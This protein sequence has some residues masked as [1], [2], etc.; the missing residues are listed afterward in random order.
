[1]VWRGADALT[2]PEIWVEDLVL[3]AR[4][5]KAARERLAERAQRPLRLRW[6]GRDVQATPERLGVRVD[7]DAPFAQ[8]EALLRRSLPA[9]V[10]AWLSGNRE[11]V[12]LRVPL[13]V[14]PD[15][16][17][18]FVTAAFR[19]IE[20]VPR[21]ARLHLAADGSRTIT[22]DQWGRAVDASALAA[23][24]A[25][26][27]FDPVNRSIEIPV[28]RV[29]PDVTSEDAAALTGLVAVG[30]FTTRFDAGQSGRS[31][32]I[33]LGARQI[34]GVVLRPGDTF[35]LNKAT[36][37]RGSLQG[38]QE[39]PVIIDGELVPGIGGG[40]SQLASTAFNLALLAGLDVIEYHNH[41]L[42]VPYLPLGRD[43]TVW[44]DQ[45]DLRFRNTLPVPAVVRAA[46]TSDSVTVELWAPEP[47]P[48][49]VEVETQLIEEIPPPTTTRPDAS[50]PSGERRLVQEGRSGRTIRITQRL[51]QESQLVNER[52]LHATYRPTP[53]TWAVAP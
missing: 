40:V 12:R 15:G 46:T 51:F 29:R 32:N 19:E 41:S 31:A 2:G 4:S 23:L 49:R 34:D 38:Y 9:Q 1:M 13:R 5:P 3:D 22:P 24:V 14:D 18:R 8:A 44:Y 25:R 30:S 17:A 28:R 20:T 7:L 11:P 50:V 10:G 6:E 36:G 45:L 35:S 33:R 53:Q 42:P 26:A 48:W 39:A 16:L 37:P 52:R 43:A 47:P 27:V 21:S